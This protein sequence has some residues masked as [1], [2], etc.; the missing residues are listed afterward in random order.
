M[1]EINDASVSGK[2]FSLQIHFTVDAPEQCPNLL[3]KFRRPHVLYELGN[4]SDLWNEVDLTGTAQTR[5]WSLTMRVCVLFS[6]I[7]SL[8]LY[9]GTWDCTATEKVLRF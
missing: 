3:K 8:L 7:I 1:Y 5:R 2:P 9:S 6:L 4:T